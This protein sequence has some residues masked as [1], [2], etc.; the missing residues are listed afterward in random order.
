MQTATATETAT[1]TETASPT[2]AS[3]SLSSP[4]SVTPTAGPAPSGGTSVPGWLWGLLLLAVAALGTGIVL[5]VRARRHSGRHTA[6]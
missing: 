4:G 5:I 3:P 2:L 6:G 1:T